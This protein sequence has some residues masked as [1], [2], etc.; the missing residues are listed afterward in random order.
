MDHDKIQ[1][2]GP[3]HYVAEEDEINLLE[4]ILVIAKHKRLIFGSCLVTFVM[5]LGFS[6]LLPNIYSATTRILPPQDS[7]GA[8][9]VD[10]TL[11]NTG[12]YVSIL[13]GPSIADFIIDKFNLMEGPQGKSR[14]LVYQ[15]LE[16]R[17]S[18]SASKKNQFISITVE[19][20][21]PKRA[22]DMANAYVEGL[23]KQADKNHLQR[24]AVLRQFLE[25]R[26]E[27]VKEDLVQA[28][29][30]VKVFQEKNKTIRIDDQTKAII[31]TIAKIKGELASKEIELAVSM[32][33]Q[34]QQTPQD[35]VLQEGF[36]QLK[37]QINVLEH[38]SVGAKVPG[39]VHLVAF[40]GPGLGLQYARLLRDFRL[41]VTLFELLT[42]QYEV[43][44][45]EE[46]KKA[47]R[48]QVLRKAFP[49]P[50]KS[51]P[52]RS[53]IVLLSTLVALFFA[54]LAAFVREY[55][56]HMC[57]EDRQRWEAIKNTLR[58][59]NGAKS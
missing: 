39:D 14:N 7:E 56:H 36:K 1:N 46:L 34:G 57:D 44:R 27:A 3:R 40:A 48:I 24:I 25:R 16:Q 52:K 22:A 10:R 15:A 12:A 9:L 45:I 8:M 49:P 43:A 4:L 6:L 28:E 58:L 54:V 35:I 17:V 21:D 13:K 41:Q 42:R 31:E 26:L 32:S 51:K 30:K 5:A 11:P 2:S 53:M 29:Q 20:K 47:P 23:K 38:S 18:I 55:G 50:T 59:W 37:N 33:A 19:D